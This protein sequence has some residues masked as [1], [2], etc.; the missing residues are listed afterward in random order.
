ML[1]SLHV[2][3]YYSLWVFV[4]IYIDFKKYITYLKIN[5]KIFKNILANIF[6]QFLIKS[7]LTYFSQIFLKIYKLMWL[8]FK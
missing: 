4:I 7:V 1:K 2:Q 5:L 6:T 8:E 3:E